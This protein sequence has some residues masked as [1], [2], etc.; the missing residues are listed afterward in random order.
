M[1]TAASHL[2][3]YNPPLLRRYIRF[4]Y[5]RVILECTVVRAAAVAALAQFGA[6][7][8]ELLPNVLVL[9]ARCQM[10]FDDEVRDRA[11]YYHSILSMQNKHLNIHYVLE[12]LQVSAESAS[13]C[14]RREKLSPPS[15]IPAALRLANR[16]PFRIWKRRSLNTC[17]TRPASRST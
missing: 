1:L 9:L 8:P 13:L 6:A 4:I 10:D 15:L 3:Q 14:E 2:S 11:T 16:S 5:N 7:C 12:P 17:K